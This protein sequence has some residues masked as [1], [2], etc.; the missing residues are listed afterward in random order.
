VCGQQP[1]ENMVADEWT[2]VMWTDTTKYTEDP[3]EAAELERIDFEIME[4]V[5]KR[6]ADIVEDP[7]TAASL[8]PWYGVRCK[9]PCFHD[10]YLPA[11]NRPNVH[12]IDTHGMGVERITEN[13]PV[14]DGVE[15][16]VDLL[17][18]ASGFDVAA[19][20]D[21]LGFVPKG[22]NG[23]PMTESWGE[24]PHSLHGVMTRD[25]PNLLMISTVQGGFGT[26]FVHYLTETSKHCAAI[27]RMCL[28]EGISQIEPSAQAEEDWFNVLMSKVMGVGMYNASC[29][30]GYL[31][32]EQQEGDMKA[33]RGASFMGSVEEYADHLIAWRE[34][35]ELAGVEVKKAK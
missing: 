16:P 31:N 6:I 1:E 4:G 18:Y 14:V 21:R 20:Y 8:Q 35:G 29:T 26:N 13:G 5:R 9:R 24:G 2:N 23:V 7:E 25:F 3:A 27:I 32:R 12:L 28:D 19:T 33:A 22:R 11:F 10:E 34:A 15:Y 30:P 17:I